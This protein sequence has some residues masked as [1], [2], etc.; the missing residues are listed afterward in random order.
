MAKM[1]NDEIKNF[2]EEYEKKFDLIHSEIDQF[3]KKLKTEELPL[4]EKLEAIDL[5]EQKFLNLFDEII[6]YA[7]L[8]EKVF[9]RFYRSIVANFLTNMG[10]LL[11]LFEETTELR[12][13]LNSI[14]A[15]MAKMKGN[16][17]SIETLK[18]KLHGIS[19]DF[20]ANYLS[21]E[22]ESLEKL[23][24]KQIAIQNIQGN[25]YGSLTQTVKSKEDFSLRV[26]T[27]FKQSYE[28]VD[29]ETNVSLDQKPKIKKNLRTLE[30]EL[31]NKAPDASKVQSLWKRLKKNA[32]WLV[33][34]IS[35]I[36]EELA[37]KAFGV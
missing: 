19:T 24:F 31:Q 32:K 25:N 23:P 14:T 5:M 36:I 15:G 6:Y 16:T 7:P 27:I 22:L 12:E 11:F 3:K 28:L 10:A 20:L 33:P 8:N 37:K 17:V 4:T 18:F 1:G 34:T 35:P 21:K 30:K 9:L 2:V 26:N 13:G 29:K